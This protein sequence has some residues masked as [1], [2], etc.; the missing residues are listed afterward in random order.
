[1]RAAL[2]LVAL[3]LAG[4][5]SAGAWLREEKTGFV[6]YS[7]TV[8]ETLRI[9]G[10]LYA[11]YGLRPKLTMGIKV[12]VDM[13]TGQIGS[14]TAIVFIRKPIN[15]G[16]RSYNLAY[17]IGLGSTFGATYEP[18]VRTGLSYGRG[19]SIRDRNGW[20]AIDGTIE[21]GTGE[22]QD[23]LKLDTTVGL[24]LNDRFKVMMQVFF[25]HEGSEQYT[26]IAPS[27]IWQPKPKKPSYVLGLESKNG[28]LGLKLGMWREF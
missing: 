10:S 24:A 19:F 27:V 28:V 2:L 21:W 11:E 6:S 5:A 7:G 18:L 16:E 20:V 4:P 8:D 1:M 12:D 17:E 26:T 9:E 23:V 14:G 15:T 13:S 25:S 3:M 22:A